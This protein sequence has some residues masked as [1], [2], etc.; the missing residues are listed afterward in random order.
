M[1]RILLVEDE[2][3]LRRAMSGMIDWQSLG[4]EPPQTAADGQEALNLFDAVRPDIVLS[5]INMPRISGLDMARQML[6]L[7]PDV[8]IIFFSAYGDIAYLQEALRMG[9]VDYLLKPIRMEELAAAIERAAGSLEK[10]ERQ[11]AHSLLLE[12]YGGQ[13]AAPLIKNL[14][15]G[16]IPKPE[17]LNQLE[18][19]GLDKAADYACAFF[20]SGIEALPQNA[21]NQ[22]Q[23]PAYMNAEKGL[24]I[25][26]SPSLY[27]YVYLSQTPLDNVFTQDAIRQWTL[28]WQLAGCLS[29]KITA[30]AIQRKL[31]G[32]YGVGAAQITL[33]LDAQK[34]DQARDTQRAEHLCKAI[35]TY[36]CEHYQ[37]RELSAGT[38]A[39][40]MHYTSAYIC[41]LFKQYSQVTIHEFINLYRIAKAKQL[42]SRG[43]LSITA[44]AEMTGYEN[45]NYFSRVFRKLEGVSPSDYRKELKK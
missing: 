22:L 19:V 23:P 5:D 38:I 25:R 29:I 15:L 42:L 7:R 37:Q 32:L 26:L 18:S 44:I 27:A 30:S 12:S 11:R 9:S 43:D 21:P 6:A 41:T 10:I 4:A 34:S 17:L 14:L 8:R 13:L 33:L 1:L 20:L 3:N 39:K 31:I 28:K 24:L 2:E 36:I 16:E 40:A 45:D 35:Q